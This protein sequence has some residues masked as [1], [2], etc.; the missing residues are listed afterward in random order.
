M[1]EFDSLPRTAASYDWSAS[2]LGEPAGWPAPLRAAAD[3]LLNSPL[4]G[5]LVWGRETVLVFNEAYAALA[6]LGC[7][8]VPGGSVPS[9]LPPPLSSAGAALQEAWDGQPRVVTGAAPSFRRAE[10]ALDYSC[11]LWL[12][13]V[14]DGNGKVGMNEASGDADGE[15]G[16]RC[17]APPLRMQ[18]TT[19]CSNRSFAAMVF[20]G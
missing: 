9:V 17:T 2:A 19:P 5:L 12:T 18:A 8:R 15:E 7:G 6:G 3:L 14:L 1:P 13:P 20:R 4:P 11:D 16:E 10:G